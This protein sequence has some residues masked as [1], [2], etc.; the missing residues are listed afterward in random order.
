M[1]EHEL[2]ILGLDIQDPLDLESY[3]YEYWTDARRKVAMKLS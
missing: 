1:D 3:L 2:L